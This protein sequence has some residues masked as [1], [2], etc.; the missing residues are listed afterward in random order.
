VPRIAI[1]TA[2]G[3]V[4]HMLRKLAAMADGHRQRSAGSVPH[5]VRSVGYLLSSTVYGSKRVRFFSGN[6]QRELFTELTQ[7]AEDGK[8][9]PVVDTVHQLSDIAAAHAALE[10]GGVRGKH[11][12]EVTPDSE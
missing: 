6:P 11:I 1:L 7:L 8:V 2:A 3:S 12:I 5:L 9:R 4:R 10:A